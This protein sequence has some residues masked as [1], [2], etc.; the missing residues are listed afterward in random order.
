MAIPPCAGS[1]GQ[2]ISDH[3]F[4]AGFDLHFTLMTLDDGPG[5]DRVEHA[6]A[7][8]DDAL[9]DLRRLMTV[10]MQQ[11]RWPSWLT[12]LARPRR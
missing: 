12:L 11:L 2:E 7:E 4:A 8:I 1:V 9:R 5:R 6:V 10:I 3:L